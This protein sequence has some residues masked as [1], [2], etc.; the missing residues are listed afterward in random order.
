MIGQTI[1]HYRIVARLGEGGMGVVYRAED[2]SLGRQVAVKFLSP[3]L[4]SDPEARRRFLREACAAASLDHPGICTVYDAGEVDGQL[5]MAMALLE[6]QTLRERI[7]AGPLPIDAAVE[8]A[9]QLAEAL[10]DAHGKGVVHRDVK[11]T[12]IM[13]LPHGQAKVMDFGLAHLAGGS[14]L[15]QAGTTLGTA[16]YM[17]PEQ[18]RGETTDARSD[19]WS[20]GGVLYEM[21]SGRLPFASEHG[22]GLVYAILHEEPEPLTGLRTGVPMELEKVVGKCLAKDAGLRYQHADELAVDLRRLLTQSE[23]TRIAPRPILPQTKSPKPRL[24]IM[25]AASLVMLGAAA[26]LLV[27]RLR[28]PNVDPQSMALA[29]IDFRD[30]STPDD[31]TVSAGMSGLLQVGLVEI[32]PIRVISPEYLL[33]LRRRL[34]GAA[35]GPIADDQA[36]EVA[37]QSGATLLLCGQMTQQ[38]K[39][40]AVMWRLVDARDGKSLLA[41]RAE[42]EMLAALADR[43]IGDVLP[44]LAQQAGTAGSAQAAPPTTEA[45]TTASPAAY[46]HFM[47]GQLLQEAGQ[48]LEAS[49]E[50]RMAARIDTTFALASLWLSRTIDSINPNARTLEAGSSLEH[51]WRHRDRLNEA[52]RMRAEAIRL[53]LV[54]ENSKASAAFERIATRWPDDRRSLTDLYVAYEWEW[55]FDEAEAVVNQAATLYPDDLVLHTGRVTVQIYRGHLA[56]AAA[57]SRQYVARHRDEASAWSI[58]GDAQMFAGLQD[59]AAFSYM[60]A[61]DLGR[62]V[63]RVWLAYARGDLNRAIAI[64]ESLAAEPRLESQ[65]RVGRLVIGSGPP[66]HLAGL[67]AEA[68]RYRETL[69]IYDLADSLDNGDPVRR[70]RRYRLLLEMNRP[71]E[72]LALSDEM[73]RMSG[74][75][76]ARWGGMVWRAQALALMG[77]LPQ[78]HAALDTIRENGDALIGGL[79][80]I[81][82]LFA[83][84]FVALSEDKPKSAL[85]DLS[86][87]A[88]IGMTGTFYD[89]EYRELLARAY[90]MG[91]RPGDAAQ[92]H[93][94]LLRVYGGHAL[95]HYELGRIYE[96]MKRPQDARREYE[97]FLVIWAKADRDAPQLLEARRRLSML[98]MGRAAPLQCPNDAN[99]TRC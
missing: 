2:L 85:G 14:Q 63:P 17:S 34:F 47:T 15:T 67:L 46:R 84:A 4:S 33:D 75:R 61:T 37:R 44:V 68:G 89:I 30:L 93:T 58:L 21:V 6:G 16:P 7:A 88:E 38:A 43:I 69:A 31:L 32:S 74:S 76:R 41:R 39:S 92:V 42:G 26:W 99:P 29:V 90:R 73:A 50:F 94:D 27:P 86:T 25:A 10:A 53:R 62:P 9:M 72:V 87:L 23:T 82:E 65:I 59:S 95:S 96:E 12:N 28:S 70:S 49:N 64:A 48:Y 13:L 60:R 77:S 80:R 51:A 83:S 91:G 5:F 57:I 36:L 98:S 1:S 18:T 45:F 54:N 35:R 3:R 78:A 66:I 56:E 19:I 20:L 11:P 71:A 97:R 81:R 52:D 24:W 79:S 40:R 8:I 22:P 55:R